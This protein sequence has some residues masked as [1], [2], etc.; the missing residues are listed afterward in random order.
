MSQQVAED[1]TTGQVVTDEFTAMVAE[2]EAK[3]RDTG[4]VV[5]P[6]DETGGP[7]R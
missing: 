1:P 5:D 7:F 4:H 2:L 6:K 3:F